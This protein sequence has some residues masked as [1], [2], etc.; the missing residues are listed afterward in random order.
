MKATCKIF[1]FVFLLNTQSWSQPSSTQPFHLHQ[2]PKEGILLDKGWKFMPGDNPDWAHPDWDD[3]DWQDIDPTQDIKN[4]PILW[5]H[6]IG[7]F[8]LH[9]SVDSALTKESLALLVEQTGASE[10]FLNGRII[11]RYGQISSQPGQIQAVGP[12]FGEFISLQPGRGTEQVLAV[13]FA[14]QKGIPYL[15]FTGWQNRAMA[16][17]VMKMQGI[18]HLISSNSIVFFLN[19]IKA[20]W[21]FILVVLHLVLY[22]IDRA[23]KANLYF[24]IFSF[25][26]SITFYCYHVVLY[27]AQLTVTKMYVLTFANFVVFLSLLFFL[28]AIYTI[29]GQRRG[30]FFWILIA[31]YFLSLLLFFDA[32]QWGWDLSI[33][34]VL[35]IISVVLESIRVSILAERRNQSGARIITIGAISSMV[36][37]MLYC[38]MLLGLLPEG[39]NWIYGHFAFNA[40][41]LSLPLSISIYL[42]LGFSFTKRSLAAKFVEVQQ[43]ES[44]PVNDD[45]GESEA[46]TLPSKS[47]TP[48]LLIVEDN[49][50]LRHFVGRYLSKNYSVMEAENGLVGY[51]EAINNPPDLV[52]SDIMMPELDGVTLCQKLKN[53]IRT[54]HIPIILLTAKADIDSKLEGLEAGAD[55]YLPKPFQLTELEVRVKNLIDQRKK[56]RERFT[57]GLILKPADIAVTSS[58]ERFLQKALDIMEENMGNSGFG[59]K[60]F[61]REIGMSR[62]Q[63]HR[64][65]TGLLNHSASEFIRMMRLKRAGSLLHQH[66]GNV[67]EVSFLVGFSSPNYFSKCF[68][69]FYGQTPS[70]YVRLHITEDLDKQDS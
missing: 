40:G 20:G 1:L 55:D 11:G 38:I 5:Q 10:I 51:T 28:L 13:R 66:H 35:L 34:R 67:S 3:R 36:F 60:I 61:S 64:K 59:V 8:R 6:T 15:Q 12:L 2:L 22:C 43:K 19:S 25:F 52:I 23:Q 65:M 37:Y 49:D 26:T 39:P 27:Q 41:L 58:D 50:E 17:R 62:T 42:A 45:A 29:Y 57:K 31:S 70:E 7:W 18:T 69:D 68:H 24:F 9:F 54:S 32:Y 44:L 4:L 16:L 47:K 46:E 21:F 48:H 33:L 63:L 14:L 56:L 30:N 53:D